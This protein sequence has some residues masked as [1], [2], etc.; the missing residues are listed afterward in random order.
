[1]KKPHELFYFFS[2]TNA[3]A[4]KTAL[5][6]NVISLVT[7]AATLLSPS[8]SQPLAFLNMAF[9]QS[10]LTALGI[11]DNLGDTQ[12]AA[13]MYADA[14][15]LGDVQSDFEAPFQGTSIH[16]VFLI[17]SNQTS[18]IN[19]LLST[20]TGYFG[21]SISFKSQ[22]LSAARPGDQ[23]GHE[24]ERHRRLSRV[25]DLISSAD[26]GYLDGISQ[27]AISGFATNVL[28]GQSIIPSGV[29]LANRLGDTATR[30]SSG[31]TLDGSFMVFRKLQ[32]VTTRTAHPA[33]S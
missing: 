22:L 25:Y 17:G 11:T 18:Y 7:S 1:M 31:W 20:V 19:D 27:P 30:P 3:A 9:S 23:A 12:F 21:G 5:K 16:G 14:P 8:T 10:G 29:I 2:I 24:R 6:S 33:C 26:F 32:Q 28:P 4:F 15:S 13:G